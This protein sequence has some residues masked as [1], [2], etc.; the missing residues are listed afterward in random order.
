MKILWHANSPLVQSGYGNQTDIVCRWLKQAG[1][2][3]IIS[4]FY[5]HRSKV[6][7]YEGMPILPSSAEQ[8]GND[9]LISHYD[10]YRP[11]VLFLLMD[12]WILKTNILDAVPAAL[13]TPIDHHPMPPAVFEK[14]GHIKWPVAMSRHGERNMR[15]SGV[16]CFYAPHVVETNVYQPVD[17]SE[18]RK[19]YAVNEDTFFVSTV[20]ANKGFPA[21]KNPDRL[22]H[23][24][25]IFCETHPNATLY[26]HTDPYPH[27]GGLNLMD[28]CDFYG[29]RYH[30]GELNPGQSLSAFRVV[31]P[32]PYHMIRGDYGTV[33]LN[34]LYNASDA[35]V[36]PSSGEGFGIPVIEAQASGCPVIVCDFTAQSELGEAG[37]K[38]P[39]DEHDDMIYSLQGSHQCSPKIS[40]IVKG[41]E[42]A[43]EHRGDTALRQRARDFAMGYSVDCVMPKYMLPAMEIMAQGNADWLQFQHFLKRGA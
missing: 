29:L 15:M 35:F 7:N 37:Y 38:I 24:W 21:R 40:E 8:W 31:F 3:V 36:L 42:W 43:Y 33:A 18:A 16:D 12:A 5:G 4:G 26:M 1:H 28:V 23:A 2:E 34:N 22:L 17:R 11:D 39:I 30:E 41:L 32:S 14:L 6:L 25:A 20:M 27:M 19:Q 9:I 13:W 10:Y